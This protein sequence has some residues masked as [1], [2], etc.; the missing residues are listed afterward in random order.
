MIRSSVAVAMLV[1][2]GGLALAQPRE[3]PGPIAPSA[4]QG[5]PPAVAPQSNPPR[6]DGEGYDMDKPAP[7]GT[8]GPVKSN[9]DPSAALIP[10]T[11]DTANP[12]TPTAQAPTRSQK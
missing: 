8:M 6:I 1:M 2:S 7:P 11:G 3:V 4:Q 5:T 9:P 10:D 12:T